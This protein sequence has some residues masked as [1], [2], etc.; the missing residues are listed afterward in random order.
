MPFFAEEHADERDGP[1]DVQMG[2][3]IDMTQVFEALDVGFTFLCRFARFLTGNRVFVTSFCLEIPVVSYALATAN[4][5]RKPDQAFA[6]R[7][8]SHLGLDTREYAVWRGSEMPENA[9]F[10]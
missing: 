3:L 8:Y 6:E 4:S 9:N 5:S 2:L 10:I 7:Q 1:L